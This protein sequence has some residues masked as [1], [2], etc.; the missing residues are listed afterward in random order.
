[1]ANLGVLAD[2]AKLIEF[3]INQLTLDMLD[4]LLA[5]QP[6][7]VGVGVYIWNV[8]QTLRLI[9][10][11]KRISPDT[12][13]VIGGPEVSYET[14]GQRIVELSDY[15]ITGE[16][17]LAFREFC[18][19]VLAGS[20]PT[21]KVIPAALPSM[22]EL[23]L[24][25]A[26]YTEE[27]VTNRVI[28]VE[29]SRGCPFTCEFCLSA[30]E[31]PVRQFPIDDFLSEMQLLLDRGVRQFKFVDRTFNLNLR[32][33]QRILEFF[34][35][36]YTS[37][38][39]LHFEMIPDR[40]PESLREVIGR[41]PDGS[42]QFEVGV[43]TLNDE[44]C[45]LISR[46]QDV[47]KLAGNLRFLREE[48]GVHVHADLIVGLPGEDLDSFA[49]G[50]DQLVSYRPH[51]IQVGILKR[52]RGTPIIRHDA[53]WEM[54]YRDD[55]PYEVLSTKLMDAKTLGRMRRF[56]RFWDMIANS[57]NFVLSTPMIWGDSSP[58]A[59][60]LKLSDWLYQREGKAYSISLIRLSEL[61]F[62][63]LTDIAGRENDEVASVL[64]ADYRR[65]GRSDTP[66]FL[67]PFAGTAEVQSGRDQRSRRTNRQSRHLA[68]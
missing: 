24:P 46:R 4:V 58:F 47:K 7:I 26:V 43:Q 52:L 31:I 5:E 35:Q 68:E 12:V 42:L 23:V 22:D 3:G 10:A 55:P 37:D 53:E 18:Q 57:G 1:M 39:F 8:E 6:R 15:V 45:E 65:I 38:L 54:V 27:D 63:Y 14:E 59:E 64:L 32:V 13:V 20:R 50:F 16:A 44:V 30:L 51:E 2:R 62:V 67:R 66:H 60:F 29:A 21:E 9:S 49:A 61:L 33:S 48:T 40:L 17:D 36:R 34:L 41:F 11:F 56:A 28:Y 25:Y 19:D